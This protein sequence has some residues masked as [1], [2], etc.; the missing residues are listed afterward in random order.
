MEEEDMEEEDMEE[1][2]ADEEGHEDVK[3]EFPSRL[4]GC[5]LTILFLL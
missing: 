3:G 1:E 4:V 2:D 5:R